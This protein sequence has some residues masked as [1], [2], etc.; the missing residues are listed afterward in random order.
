MPSR[1][2]AS[3]RFGPTP[4]RYFTEVTSC[5][6]TPLPPLPFPGSSPAHQTLRV[7]L[8]GEH[9]EILEP[10][11]CTDKTDRHA[12]RALYGDH[13]P[14]L[15]GAVELGDDQAGERQPRGERRS[16]EH[17]SELQSRLHLVCRLLL[18]KKK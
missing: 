18:E 16:E 7:G 13:A 10:L 5:S 15:R 9:F 11:P 17:T 4:L 1:A 12:Y 8:G 14:A 2:S 6:V 3:A